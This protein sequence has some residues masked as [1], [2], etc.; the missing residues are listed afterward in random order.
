MKIIETY[1]NS[2]KKF[3]LLSCIMLTF[4]MLSVTF[5]EWTGF[6]FSYILAS[7]A[8]IFYLSLSLNSLTAS[9]KIFI[10]LGIFLV[11]LSLFLK[12]DSF[13]LIIDSLMKSAFVVAFFLSL[14]C[15]RKAA[16]S[17]PGME[18]CGR[19]LAE[20]KSNI[21]YLSLTFGGHI[22]GV[23]LS[24]GSISLLGSL[25]EKGSEQEQDLNLRKIKRKSMLLAVQRGF[26]AMTCWSPLTYSIAITTSIIPGSTWTGA[27]VSC[28]ISAL[29]LIFLGWALDSRTNSQN[30]IKQKTDVTPPNQ[31]SWFAVMPLFFIFTTLLGLIFLIQ[32]LTNLK[33]VP[34]VMLV[35]PIFSLLWII[36]QNTGSNKKIYYNSKQKVNEFINNDIYE[37]KSELVILIMAAFIGIMASSLI[38]IIAS[39]KLS[40]LESL[41]PILI[42]ISIVWIMPLFGQIGMNPILSVYLIGPLIPNAEILGISPNS[43]ILALTAGWALSGISSPYTASTLLI[44]RLGK[45][46]PIHAGLKW[47]GWFTIIGGMLLSIW[48][49][50]ANKFIIT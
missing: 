14:Q 33:A 4:I 36:F 34:V 11:L 42:L 20:Q 45:V 17:S 22:F 31:D 12:A 39:D 23:I 50:I 9:R 5:S 47:N 19:F 25:A 30:K 16:S 10:I 49:I 21:R 40:V 44:A 48:I 46:A 26:I 32:S 24:F 27:A 38:N 13:N 28:I 35:V 1:K 41:S 6:K 29:I 37:Y 43:I 15:L 8:I 7:L 2:E 18:R 3:K